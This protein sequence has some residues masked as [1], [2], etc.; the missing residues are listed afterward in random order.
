MY[1]LCTFSVFQKMNFLPQ[2]FYGMVGSLS[3]VGDGA[4]VGVLGGRW[5]G[6]RRALGWRWDG[7]WRALA[8]SEGWGWESDL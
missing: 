5:A 2:L 7:V 8:G 1:N 3:M 4:G 6:T